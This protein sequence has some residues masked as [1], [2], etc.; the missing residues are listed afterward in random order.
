MANPEAAQ[1]PPP[2][3]LRRMSYF[4][5]KCKC[6]TGLPSIPVSNA[7]SERGFSILR[8]IYTDQCPS[9]KYD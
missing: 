6:I 9:L 5:P 7:D 3:R 1:N 4:D 8:K 2:K